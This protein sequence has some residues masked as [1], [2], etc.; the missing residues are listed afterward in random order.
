MTEMK[1]T[2]KNTFDDNSN[3]HLAEN[4]NLVS[5]PTTSLKDKIVSIEIPAVQELEKFLPTSTNEE[6]YMNIPKEEERIIQEPELVLKETLLE[7]NS[8][9]DEEERPSP[10][11]ATNENLSD[12]T[13]ELVEDQPISVKEIQESANAMENLII[14][15][16]DSPAEEKVLTE[17]VVVKN[18]QTTTPKIL[19]AKE[20]IIKSSNKIEESIKSDNDV[21]QEPKFVDQEVSLIET[22]IISVLETVEP[23]MEDYEIETEEDNT[24]ALI[25]EDLINNQKDQNLELG[26]LNLNK[27]EE[28]TP[29]LNHL[30]IISTPIEEIQDQEDDYSHLIIKPIPINLKQSESKPSLISPTTNKQDVPVP[31]DSKAKLEEDLIDKNK[32]LLVSKAFSRQTKVNR[33]NI[34]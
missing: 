4:F 17:K 3:E 29:S 6:L 19:M 23:D 16:P 21:V 13:A 28:T 5:N 11:M 15:E 8:V 30:N 27:K 10:K 12:K 26:E 2:L 1:E 18:S 24:Q 33:E 25:I 32:S 14:Q 20:L 22:P 31:S 34:F 7:Q 9:I